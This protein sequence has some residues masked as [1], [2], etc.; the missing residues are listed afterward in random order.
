M[1]T[2]NPPSNGAT[3]WGT[4]LNDYLVNTLQE[5][6]DQTE[7]EFSAHAAG[8]ASGQAATSQDPHGDQAYARQLMAPIVSAINGPTGFVQL[9]S[10]GRLPSNDPWHDFRPVSGNFTT[11][12][13][14]PPQY[15]V[16]LDGE[17]KFAGYVYTTSNAYNGVA[18]FVSPLTGVYVPDKPVERPVT[19]SAAGTADTFGTP[20]LVVGTDGTVKFENL[21]T[22]LAAGTAI[23]IY[24]WYPCDAA[25]T[26]IQS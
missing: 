20:M 2:P 12:S 1:T 26:L 10:N 18:V 22:G 15:R 11:G 21:P 23:G 24:T 25:N 19:V 4:P 7:T 3:N 5:Q 13:Y 9:D 16:N 17:V 14:Y 6:A 8:I